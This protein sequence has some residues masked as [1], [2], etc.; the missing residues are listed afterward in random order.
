MNINKLKAV[1]VALTSTIV[2]LGG[3]QK[4]NGKTYQG[5][6]E[7]EFVNIASSQSGRLDKLFVNRGQN[8]SKD[9]PLFALEC[10]SEVAAVNQ[11]KS[12]LKV[13]IA[14][15]DDIQK[16]ARVEEQSVIAAKLLQAQANAE[17]LKTQYI[18]N[19]A[20]YK[21]NAISKT[22]MDNSIAAAKSSAAQVAELQNS[23]KVSKLSAREDQ[24]KA[25]KAHVKQAEF[26][27]KQAEWRLE[28]KTLRAPKNALVFDT[29]YREG[30][31]VPV[32]G[33]VARLLPPENIKI[34]FFVSQKI[35]EK[36]G[37]NQKVYFHLGQSETKFAGVLSYI[38]AEAEYTPP[39]IYSNESKD[40]LVFM[41][42]AYPKP[43]DAKLFHPG[44]PVKVSL[45]EL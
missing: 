38:S 9:A 12:E 3:C 16:G 22:E 36:L 21:T 18:R 41:V 14:T 13:A 8:I 31:F 5:Y 15:L 2:V 7:G 33:I 1:I 19:E 4:E 44:Q 23:L 37:L 25:Q 27:L 39:L 30:E 32:G 42:E 35:A 34:R 28:Q 26:V 20:L 45:D 40:R 29:V 10:D 43:E 24:I 11:A 17:N 6:A